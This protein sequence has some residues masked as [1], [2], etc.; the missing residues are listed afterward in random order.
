[1]RHGDA[2]AGEQLD[3]FGNRVDEIV[4]LF[5]VLVEEKVQLI[6][7]GTRQLSMV[8]LVNVAKRDCVCQQL[9]QV[10]DA[11]PADAVRQRHWQFDQVP[12]WLNLVGVLAHQRF[13]FS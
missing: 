4:L 1:M 5:E 2:D 10:L 6:E 13:C 3:P 11:L 7:R 8:P 9:I 12:V